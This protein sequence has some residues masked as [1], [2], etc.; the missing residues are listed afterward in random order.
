MTLM[1]RRAN[2][3]MSEE[4]KSKN[5]CKCGRW[6]SVPIVEEHGTYCPFCG[7]EL[8]NINSDTVSTTAE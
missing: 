6:F 3:H 2:I 1:Y 7:T 5:T 4:L 8:T